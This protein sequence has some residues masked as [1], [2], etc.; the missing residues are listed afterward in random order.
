MHASASGTEEVPA[1]EGSGKLAPGL[2]GF[3]SWSS[4]LL[5]VCGARRTWRG[6]GPHILKI[7]GCALPFMK[8][9][10]PDTVSL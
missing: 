10:F 4:W 8:Y 6:M 1:S 2:W 3:A 5:L 9:S 7:K